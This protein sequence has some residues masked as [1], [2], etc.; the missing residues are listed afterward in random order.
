[1]TVTIKPTIS[2]ENLMLVLVAIYPDTIENI[3]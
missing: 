1:M 3:G 2:H